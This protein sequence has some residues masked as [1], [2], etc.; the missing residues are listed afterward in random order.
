M[1]TPLCSQNLSTIVPGRLPRPATAPWPWVIS[2][3]S[4]LVLA[5][6]SALAVWP[7][8]PRFQGKPL[9]YWLRGFDGSTQDRA[10]AAEAVQRIGT[11]ALGPLVGMINARGYRLRLTTI[12]ENPARLKLDLVSPRERRHRA[13]KGFLALGNA[14]HSAIPALV[15]SLDDSRVAPSAAQA[16]LGIGS[17]GVCALAETLS[18]PQERARTVA[19]EALHQ[20]TR[21]F[22]DLDRDHTNPQLLA[23]YDH[24]A[25][26]SV[27]PLLRCLADS[28]PARRGLAAEALGRLGQQPAVAIP[29][30]AA[31]L[32]DDQLFPR[33]AAARALASFGAKA[34]PAL[35]AIV[36]YA[37]QNTDTIES[38]NALRAL[39]RIDP[40]AAAQM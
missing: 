1:N 31:L 23:A 6:I 33:W 20:Y 4:L 37:R 14:A 7:H 28:D 18:R 32:D 35:P 24:A 30:L 16:L 2:L 19:L 3:S 25:K 9:T 13:V 36:R 15:G 27:P 11:D 12:G 29:A 38:A 10:Q 21:R 34:K 40:G 39:K 26:V 22:Q 5:V 17:Q 8:E